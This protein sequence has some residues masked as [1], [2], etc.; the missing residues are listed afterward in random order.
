MVSGTETTLRLLLNSLDRNIVTKNIATL[1]KL[2]F[3]L[4]E[5]T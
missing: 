1:L 2:I 4:Q 5:I 3:K